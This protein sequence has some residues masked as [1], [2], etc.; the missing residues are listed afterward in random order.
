MERLPFWAGRRFAL[1]SALSSIAGC[2]F[3]S[4]GLPYLLP[5]AHH[6]WLTSGDIWGTTNS[7]QYVSYG[8]LSTVYSIN[9]WYGALPGFLLIYAP[10]VALGD[11]F[12]LLP[13]YPYQLAHPSMWLV[14]G[15]FCFLC[16]ATLLPA[17]DYLAETISV[18]A[19]RRRWL[20]GFT[21]ALVVVPTAV[22]AGHPEDLLALASVCAC[23]A[24]LV[25]GRSAAAALW[26]MPGI[27]MQ[28]WAGLL[29][30]ILI[31]ASPIGTRIRN[32]ILAAG[33]PAAMGVLF[34]STDYKDA[35]L[36]LL[37]QPMT[38][39]GQH[40]PWW[41]VASTVFVSNPA[42]GNRAVVAGASTRWLAVIAAGAVA[43]WVW[44]R[45]SPGA[46]V[47]GT[48]LVLLGRGLF[49]TQFWPYYLAPAAVFLALLA[50]QRTTGSPKR[51]VVGLIGALLLYGSAP[52]AGVGVAYSPVLAL[53]IIVTCAGL[54][55]QASYPGRTPLRLVRRSKVPVYAG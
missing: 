11:H 33:V 2:A 20:V 55:L 15:P 43:G 3:V 38:G 28:T 47:S 42:F 6:P 52:M 16:G 36:D 1:W 14:S 49:E 7:A 50:A 12:N 51:F 9:P 39:I 48:A 25:Q 18:P 30:P 35:S 5:I 29:I 32:L 37:H 23:V 19:T 10:V 22:L 54:C 46:I 17:L 34:L 24:L 44:K 45:P 4:F 27:M 41:S 8:G 53:L 26:L 21:G 40:L 13:A 31:A